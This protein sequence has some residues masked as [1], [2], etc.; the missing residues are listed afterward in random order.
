MHTF[1]LLGKK[2]CPQKIPAINLPGY[3]LDFSYRRNDRVML[4]LKIL[5]KIRYCLYPF[6]KISNVKFFVGAVQ[7]IAD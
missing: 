4:P 3:K 5:M 2:P 7:V 6:I 1:A